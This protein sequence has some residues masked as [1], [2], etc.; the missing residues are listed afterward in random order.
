[1]GCGIAGAYG[2]GADFNIGV[3][4]ECGHPIFNVGNKFPALWEALNE[5]S[6]DKPATND[7][8]LYIKEDSI[9]LAENT[10]EGKSDTRLISS[11]DG[12]ENSV[13]FFHAVSFYRWL[14]C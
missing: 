6:Q 13:R 14:W 10:H 4:A 12:D 5:S 2:V 3:H 7:N 11:C 8:L 9:M 1:V